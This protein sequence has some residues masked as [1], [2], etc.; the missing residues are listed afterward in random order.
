MIWIVGKD[1]NTLVLQADVKTEVPATGVAT[2]KA[3]RDFDGFIPSGSMIRTT[4]AASDGDP[5]LCVG[6]LNSADSWDW[7]V[8]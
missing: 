8:S 2:A 7:V 3:M 5:T 4:K 1:G 6:I